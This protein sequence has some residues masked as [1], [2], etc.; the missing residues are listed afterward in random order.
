MRKTSIFGSTPTEVVGPSIVHIEGGE[1]LVQSGENDLVAAAK[2]DVLMIGLSTRCQ[3]RSPRGSA[4]A[5][6]FQLSREWAQEILISIAADTESSQPNFFVH[7]AGTDAARQTGHL[8]RKFD[9]AEAEASAGDR[10]KNLALCLELLA[11]TVDARPEVLAPG[12]QRNRVASE[13]LD[14]LRQVT[15]ELFERSLEKVSISEVAA[16]M[17]LSERQVSRLFRQ[18]FGTTFREHMCSLQLERA[19]RLLRETDARIV[20]VALETGWRSLAHFNRVFRERVG[21]TP[22]QY[23]IANVRELRGAQTAPPR[24][25]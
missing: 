23:R 9:A 14:R 22:S 16:A 25:H 13:G 1:L 5:Q 18:A 15:L 11:Y 4:V 8:L 2:G 3:L 6:I 10:L 24:I 19:K 7:R 12:T 17:K 21:L 20:D